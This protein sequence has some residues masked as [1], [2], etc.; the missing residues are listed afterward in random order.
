MSDALFY[1][2]ALVV[3]GLSFVLLKR[4]NRTIALQHLPKGE[5][6]AARMGWQFEVGQSA[7][8]EIY[9][10]RGTT[11]GITW[12]AEALRSGRGRTRGRS[13]TTLVRWY[14]LRPLPVAGP[15]AMLVADRG[16]DGPVPPRIEG[17]GAI[18][19]LGARLVASALDKGL[20]VLFGEEIGRHVD[21]GTL[22]PVA[23]IQGPY[24]GTSVLAAGADRASTL[25]LFQKLDAPLR[26]LA[27]STPTLSLLVTPAGLA[28]SAKGWVK[29]ADGLVPIVNAGVALVQAIGD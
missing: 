18:A 29:D 19:K 27:T 4:R 2:F 3:M 14:A 20:D 7:L 6:D 13:A 11:A 25:F 28:I 8:F 1:L 5:A 24:P 17:D 16:E 23:D 10:W 9:R 26:S 15:A 21:A 22:E 12:V